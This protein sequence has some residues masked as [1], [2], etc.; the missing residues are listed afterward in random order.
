LLVAGVDIQRVELSRDGRDLLTLDVS[1]HLDKSEFIVSLP[2]DETETIMSER[3]T[4]MGVEVQYGCKVVEVQTRNDTATTTFANRK[5]QDYDWIVG[6][7]GI[8]SDV[9]QSLDIPHEGYDLAEEWSIADLKV[10]PTSYDM[11]KVSAWMLVGERQDGD[12]LVLFP[13][14]DER[15]RLVSSTPD[16]TETLPIDL[17]IKEVKH[18][19]TFTISVRQAKQY[20]EG[21]VLLAGDAAHVHSPVGGRGMNLGIAGGEAVATAIIQ[22]NPHEYESK[23]RQKARQAINYTERAR[24][25]VK[26]DNRLLDIGLHTA[27]WITKPFATLAAK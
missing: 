16:S 10:D 21:R 17:D 11:Q 18:A 19:G 7:D 8:N 24:K 15:V 14:T 26:S 25:I 9:R 2:Q 23:R 3:L 13:M 12:A 5:S 22:N 27:G 4:E 1:A 20:S 6:A